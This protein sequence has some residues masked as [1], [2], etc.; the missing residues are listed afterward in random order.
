MRTD[1]GDDRRWLGQAPRCDGLGRVA[2]QGRLDVE[3]VPQR[4]G[5]VRPQADG[6]L[7]GPAQ[8]QLVQLLGRRRAEIKLPRRGRLGRRPLGTLSAANRREGNDRK[9]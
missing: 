8:H 4:L 2:R 7:A 9:R 5:E 6:A 1:I 3:G